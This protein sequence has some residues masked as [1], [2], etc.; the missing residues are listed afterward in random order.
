MSLKTNHSHQIFW[1]VYICCWFVILM[2]EQKVFCEYEDLLGYC[3]LDIRKMHTVSQLC[4][5]ILLWTTYSWFRINGTQNFLLWSTKKR[6]CNIEAI[7]VCDYLDKYL[8]Y[9]PQ[10]FDANL[11]TTYFF[12]F[13]VKIK[14]MLLSKRQVLTG[15]HR[16]SLR[17]CK[18]SHG[19]A[20]FCIVFRGC[21]LFCIGSHGLFCANCLKILQDLIKFSWS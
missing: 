8:F 7:L 15:S 17:F 18:I 19:F 13:F 14:N 4:S 11:D 10:M 9:A 3:C 2:S 21:T 1:H 5:A 20:W 6:T 12:F 16:C